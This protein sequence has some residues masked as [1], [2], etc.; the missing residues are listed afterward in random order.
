MAS[1]GED[2]LPAWLDEGLPPTETSFAAIV[3]AYLASTSRPRFLLALTRLEKE[4]EVPAVFG[5]GLAREARTFGKLAETLLLFQDALEPGADRA[6]A[7]RRAYQH[8]IV[9]TDGPIPVH[10]GA[11][12]FDVFAWAAEYAAAFDITL[13]RTRDA[14]GRAETLMTI[15]DPDRPVR[16]AAWGSVEGRSSA[17]SLRE[18][19]QLVNYRRYGRNDVIPSRLFGFDPNARAHSKANAIRLAELSQ[20]VY[21]RESY[22]RAQL[23]GIGYAPVRWIEDSDTD[24]QAVAA[25]GT[26]HAVVVFR[27]TAGGRDI[28]TDLLFRKVPFH[29]GPSGAPAVGRVHR[30]FAGALD[31]VWSQVL[32]AAQELGRDR[33]LFVAGHSLGA[34][35][36]QLAAMRLASHGLTIAGLY[37]YGSP[38]VGDAAFRDAYNA[39]L[40]D[41][42]FM[43]INDADIVT[44]VPPWWTG[45]DHVAQ[46]ARRFDKTHRMSL[47]ESAP[48]ARAA[49]PQG[50][51]AEAASRALMEQAAA[52]VSES[53]RYL[54]VDDIQ[55]ASAG[56]MTYGA[57][58]EEG[59]LDDH[60]I[61]QYLFKF[62]CA[63]VED[64]IAGA[65]PI[66]APEVAPPGPRA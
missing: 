25:G 6:R 39:A 9:N 44:T 53:R 32:A 52:V 54:S 22:V 63:I 66:A 51:D 17:W 2:A 40:G 57:A 41:R 59:R 38:R 45:F 42:T 24:T 33:P 26:D 56:G 48:A 4:V 21:L 50:A 55:A 28:L 10:P 29:A 1:S 8:Y 62:A 20:L 58:F 12:D 27:G 18:V 65:D 36:A 3:D 13:Q 19:G 23:G 37:T 43:H 46:P 7:I 47:D 49:A 11:A 15:D 31:S 61:A 30:G 34:A 64:R 16:C 60:G 5:R 35:L 14:E